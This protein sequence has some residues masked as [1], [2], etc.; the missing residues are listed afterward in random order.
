MQK[1]VHIP[2]Q[3]AEAAARALLQELALFCQRAGAPHCY[4]NWSPETLRDY[5]EFHCCHDSLG[6]VRA[7]GTPQKESPAPAPHP[8]PLTP[9]APLQGCAVIWRTTETILRDRHANNQH[10]FDWQPPDPAGDSLFIADVVCLTPSALI[11]LMCFFA[12]K[13]PDWQNL[14]MF[15]YRKRKLV[16]LH[17]RHVSRIIRRAT[18][19]NLVNR[20][21]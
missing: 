2:S 20:Q 12:K 14:K 10:I 4:Q 3:E 1:T 16:R 5:L 13:H 15:T 19:A 18:R 9:H 7:F 8:S 21:S 6:F 11:S 17:P